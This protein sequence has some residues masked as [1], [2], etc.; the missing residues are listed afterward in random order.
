MKKIV[1]ALLLTGLLASTAPAAPDGFRDSARLTQRAKALSGN[2]AAVI[3]CARTYSAWRAK[4]AE[5][6]GPEVGSGARGLTVYSENA[7]YIEPASCASL[8]GWLRGKSVSTWSVGQGVLTL[9]HEANH[10]RGIVDERTAECSALRALPT[11]LRQHFGV[12]KVK[13]LREMLAG[14]KSLNRRSPTI[15]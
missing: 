3:Y 10:L 12:K 2:E 15:C 4:I 8:E 9:A 11:T 6:F 7:A 1:L 5:W 14:A 13:T